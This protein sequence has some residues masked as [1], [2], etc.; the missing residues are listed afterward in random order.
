MTLLKVR[1]EFRTLPWQ[2][3]LGRVVRSDDQSCVVA[4]LTSQPLRT[5]DFGR[6]AGVIE[7]GKAQIVQSVWFVVLLGLTVG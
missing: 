1:S 6:P 7:L 3:E 5:G 2:S 4:E